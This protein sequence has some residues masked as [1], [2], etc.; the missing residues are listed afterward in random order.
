MIISEYAKKRMKK[1]RITEEEIRKCLID[2]KLIFQK[3]N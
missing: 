1:R 2:G 3:N